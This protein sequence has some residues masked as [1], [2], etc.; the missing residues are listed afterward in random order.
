MNN[1]GLFVVIEGMDGTG[2]ELILRILFIKNYWILMK[3]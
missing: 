3:K 1:K 2:K